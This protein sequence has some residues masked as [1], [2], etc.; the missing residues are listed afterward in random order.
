M[1]TVSFLN[2][3]RNWCYLFMLKIYVEIFVRYLIM[4]LWLDSVLW[5]SS[6]LNPPW[7]KIIGLYYHIQKNTIF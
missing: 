4:Y 3:H 1:F 7:A 5:Q 6:C 2:C